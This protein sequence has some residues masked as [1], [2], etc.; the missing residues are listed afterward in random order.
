MT[1]Q[2][3]WAK[4]DEDWMADGPT[5]E[6]ERHWY[7]M[8][9]GFG[10]APGPRNIPVGESGGRDAGYTTNSKLETVSV[11][12]LTDA[13]ALEPLLPP[14]IELLGEPRLMITVL[15]N[16]RIYFHA[17]Y[18]YTAMVVNI[19]VTSRRETE[20]VEGVYYPVEWHNRPDNMMTAREEIGYPA[21]W[22]DIDLTPR[23]TRACTAHGS[24]N[25]FRF[26][27]LKV[28]DLEDAPPAPYDPV[29][30]VHINYKYVPKGY[31]AG[32][33]FSRVV[34][35]DMRKY[36]AEGGAADPTV[37]EDQPTESPI[38]RAGTGTFRFIPPTW[39]DMPTQFHVVEKLASI[40]LH[41]FL[42]AR[43]ALYPGVRGMPRQ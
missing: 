18:T 20:P 16:H 29:G 41:E 21:L 25:G 14:G 8:P 17:G 37:L 3:D 10:R 6:L 42:P 23:G 30:S 39:Q 32:K 28:N 15:T 7:R 34:V 2:T 9:V 35:N 38:L 33:E 40:P 13:A 12:A 36:W 5:N 24:W 1:S 11:T 4:H 31:E 26:F 22:A 27:E 19:P 43:Y